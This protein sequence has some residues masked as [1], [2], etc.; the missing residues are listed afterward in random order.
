MTNL[1]IRGKLA[2]AFACLIVGFLISS[3][4]VFV[5][6]RTLDE[7]STSAQ[8]SLKLAGRSEKLMAQM[9]EQQNALR[10][11]VMTGGADML[12]TYEA[13]KV[14]F[15]KGLNEFEQTTT[16]EAQKARIQKLRAAMVKWRADVGDAALAAMQD[17]A[18]REAAVQLT[19][20][21][22]MGELRAIQKELLD[23]SNERVEIRSV[24]Q[25]GALKF[26]TTALVVGALA[27]VA[28]ALLMG[29]LLVRAI[30]VPVTGMTQ[31][32]R[33]LAGGDNEVEVPALGRKDEVG[34][35][36]AALLSFKEAAVQK[37]ALE[38][39]S[40]EQRH[41]SDVERA[42]REREKAQEAAQ[43]AIVIEALAEALSKMA[44]GDLTHRITAEFAPK[45]ER[46]K[47]DFNVALEKLR[48]AMSS[49]NASTGS[50]RSSSDEIAQASHDLSRRTEQQAAAL[51]ET[52]AA[53]DEITATV[54]KTAE[55]ATDVSGTVAETRRDAETSGE[56]VGQAVAAMTGIESSSNQVNQII[57]V[58]DEIA[59]QTNLLAL[60]AGVEAAR[61]GD[62]G[63]GFAVVA[64]EVR[65][66]AQRSAEAAKEIKTLI[67]ES[68]KQVGQGVDL[69]AQTGQAL[70]RIMRQVA[71]IDARVQEIAASAQEQ[72]TGLHEVNA[73]VNQ[74]DQVVQQNAAMVEEAT[75]ATQALSGE[76]SNL[77][78]LVGK[79]RTVETGARNPVHAQ[80][81]R[82]T[83]FA[84][85]S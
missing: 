37:L 67:A 2:V 81:S 84:R 49:I 36:A 48:D 58:I 29:W 50:V 33:R 18:G 75:A 3:T 43:D 63:K 19:G 14:A 44:E 69:V 55:N 68:A 10:G 20:A 47:T 13:E 15:D 64:S 5:S 27:A 34:E 71:S 76:A 24:E 57:S 7:A 46:L 78:A 59:F 52:A 65:A 54:R 85:A 25:K 16:Q 80:Q 1:R 60:N 22:S 41:L 61:A 82:L 35:M 62:A 31:T 9:L 73:A 79:F 39:S 4:A 77:A 11:Y 40:A 30:A 17:P 6:L 74:M 53:L 51:E 12:Q 66:L 45:S 8:R 70:E 32:M 42:A 21:K 26:A 23:A 38:A 72:A 56:V 28:I 83:A